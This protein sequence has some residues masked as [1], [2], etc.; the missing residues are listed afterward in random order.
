[1]PTLQFPLPDLPEEHRSRL[2]RTP[3]K[4]AIVHYQGYVFETNG[5]I[6]RGLPPL[7]RST[8]SVEIG[9]GSKHGILK[10]HE[11]LRETETVLRTWTVV[12][13]NEESCF[14][15][16]NTDWHETA[17][18]AADEAGNRMPALGEV[19]ATRWKP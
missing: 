6:S 13:V 2:L 12:K 14:A 1:M 9:A 7:V 17:Q 18:Q 15:V 11:F 10:G 8:I 16:A 5:V 4:G 19:L 3:V